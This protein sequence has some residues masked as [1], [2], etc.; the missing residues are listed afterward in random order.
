M[1]TRFPDQPGFTGFDAPMRVEADLMDVEVSQGAIPEN[2]EGT[3]Y[4]VVA[5]FQWPPKVDGDFFFNGDGMVMS[6]RFSGGHA[7]FKSR[8]VR[9]PRFVAQAKERRALFGAYR[10]PYTDD[11]SVAGMSRGLANTNVFWHGG[12]LLSSKEDSPPMMI[13]PDTLETIGEHTFDGALT[14][15][16][17]TAHP[18]IDPRTGEMVFFGFAAKGETTPDIAYYEADSRG[19]VIHETWLRAPYSSMVH[20]FAVTQNFVVFPIIPLTSD[21]ERL[22]AGGPHYAWDPHKDVYLGV[23]PRKGNGADIRWYR[24]SNRFASHIMGAHDDG[25]HIFIDTPVSESNFFPF[26]PDLSGAGYEAEKAKGYLSRWTIDT[27]GESNGFTETKIARYPGEFPRMD[28]RRETLP[29]NWGVLALS[30][31]PEQ[32][33]PGRGFRWISSIDLNTGHSQIYYPGHDCSVAEPLFVPAHDNAEERE[34]YV[35]VVIGRHEEMRSDLVILDAAHLDAPPVATLKMPLRI[36][37]GLHG[38]WVSATELARE[39]TA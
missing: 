5:D 26:F 27:M 12:K 34:G 14:S 7:D 13:D 11:P 21:L 39:R 2:L 32:E 37:S 33:S 19:V 10:N 1:V 20:D 28:D 6:F 15:Q 9:T 38:N 3:Y 17:S 8:Y 16:T 35:F 18:K 23:L 24:G 29:Y 31:V 25:R 4:R 22:K 30:D 36:R